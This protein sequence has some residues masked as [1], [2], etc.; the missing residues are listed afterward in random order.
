MLRIIVLVFLILSPGTAAA[1]AWPREKGSLFLAF[2]NTVST[3]AETRY[4]MGSSLYL[5][6]GLTPRM[7][8]G[9][10]GF[11]GPKGK[12]SEAYMFLRFPVGNLERSN[13]FALTFALGVKRIPNPWGATI[14]QPQAKIG[15][16]WGRGLKHGWLAADAY[17]IVPLNTKVPVLAT[18]FVGHHNTHFSADFTWGYKHSDRLMIIGQLQTGRPANADS[19]ARF[20]PSVV[21]TAGKNAK[22]QLEIGLVKGLA[23]DDSQSVK[24]GFWRSF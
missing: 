2:S 14:E 11:L 20:A 21:W 1:G 19:Y 4:E 6:Y 7:T 3:N 12:A 17:V 10:D 15:A 23:G 9:L 5:E 18:G 22:T 13:R 24:I 16:S 8:V